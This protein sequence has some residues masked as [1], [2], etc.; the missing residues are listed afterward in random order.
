MARRAVLAVAFAAL[1]AAAPANAATHVLDSGS[2][3]VRV[4]GDPWHLEFMQAGGAP[5]SEATDTGPGP[6]STVGF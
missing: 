1:A 2:L 4:T 5:L 6:T 3:S